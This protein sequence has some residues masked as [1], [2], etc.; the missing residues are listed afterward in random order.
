MDM[1]YVLF[2]NIGRLN[3]GG[4]AGCIYGSSHKIPLNT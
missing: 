2:Q 4:V 1:T 3:T